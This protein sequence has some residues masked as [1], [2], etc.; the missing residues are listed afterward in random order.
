MAYWRRDFA[1]RSLGDLMNALGANP[2]GVLV[3]RSFLQQRGLKIG[4]VVRLTVATDLGRVLDEA[5]IVGSFNYFPTWYEG[6]EDVGPLFVGNL[7]YIFNLA[8]G[9]SP[10]RV[11]VKAKP[12]LDY[13]KTGDFELR[14]LNFRVVTWNAAIPIIDEE[15]Q[16]PEQQGVFGFLF[17]G[18]VAAAVLTVVG[19]LL[20]ALFSYQR[21]FIELGVLRAGGLSRGQMALYLAFELIFLIL[22]GAGAGT[23]LG[24]WISRQFIPY[25]Q[26]GSDVTAHIPPFQIII[27]WDAVY[28]IYILFAAL[29][30]V[31]LLLLIFLLLRMKIFQAIK[32]GETV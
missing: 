21:R 11:W 15:Q 25:L 7:D 24:A 29:F 6:Q 16:R 18:F 20:Y 28:Q 1:Q 17:I 30:G 12:N 10:Y 27:A 22:V 9:E 2:E 32:L 14:D 3:P 23:A 26:F 19:F 4:D 8:G 13:T 5:R 31:T